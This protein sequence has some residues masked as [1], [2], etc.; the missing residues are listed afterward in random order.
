MLLA[1]VALVLTFAGSDATTQVANPSR[2]PQAVRIS[3]WVALSDT[4]TPNV[5]VSPSIVT[6][7]PG[8][9]QVVRLRARE[10]CSNAWRFVVFY[11]PVVSPSATG[12]MLRLQ[13][14]IVGKVQCQTP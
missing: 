13:T 7:P 11:S 10:A 6:L 12:V 5:L 2:E 8:G 14:R 9:L 3:L 1:Q 4:S